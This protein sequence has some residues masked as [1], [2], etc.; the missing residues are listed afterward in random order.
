MIKEAI[1]DLLN[2]K[3]LSFEKMQSVMEEILKGIATPAQISAFLVLLRKK[4]ET[5]QEI[6][7]AVD[8]LLKFAQK[9][10]VDIKPIM[11]TCGTGGDSLGSFNISTA[12]AFVVSGAEITVAKHGNRAVSS[13]CGSADLLENLGIDINMDEEKIKY[14]LKNI[15]IAFL[16]APNF[17]PAMKYALPVRQQ[18]GIRTI[19]NLLGPLINPVNLTHQLIGVYDRKWLRVIAE[20]LKLLGRVHAM[21]V[22]SEDGFDEISL[23][24]KTY[25]CELKEGKIK[26]YSLNPKNFGFN[27]VPYDKFQGKDPSFNAKI[28]MEVLE[29]KRNI[30][31]DIVL[32][33][34]G[35][36]IYVAD[37]AKTIKEGIDLATYSIDSGSALKKLA[38]LREL[39]KT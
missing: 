25:V 11:D 29:G 27:L 19:F 9:I 36:A 6:Y 14:A 23:G 10:K 8:S 38:L 4:G 20:V 37:R 2:N 28:F 26:E 5:S 12:S 18:L 39:S 3:D 31:R 30:F 21:V 15:G 17:H 34:A 16:F 13:L 7:A 32:F 22:C 1:S 24:A 33:N 35:A